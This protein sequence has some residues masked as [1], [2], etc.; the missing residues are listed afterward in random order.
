[1][2]ERRVLT[3]EMGSGVTVQGD[4]QAGDVVAVT[5]QQRVEAGVFGVDPVA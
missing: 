2:T 5:G 4:A 1:M 3:D